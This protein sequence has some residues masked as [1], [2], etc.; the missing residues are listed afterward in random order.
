M[1]CYVYLLHFS[2]RYPNGRQPQHYLGV[3]R[4]LEHRFR[5][6]Q[7]GSTKSRLTRACVGLGI[8]VH[9]VTQWKFRYPKAAFDHERKL[10]RKKRSY[11]H[12]CPTCKAERR[13]GTVG[14][15]GMGRPHDVDDLSPPPDGDVVTAA[16]VPV[17]S[18]V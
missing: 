5:E 10:K 3:A 8:T 13:T 15:R 17:P 1:T 7:A 11:A 9:L 4:D 2:E 14:D 12:I 16:A 18:V 6:H